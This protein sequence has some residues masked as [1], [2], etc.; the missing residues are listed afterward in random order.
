MEFA[1]SCL[2]QELS[3]WPQQLEAEIFSK[4][5]ATISYQHSH[6]PED[7]NF[8]QHCCE[9][10]KYRMVIS[11]SVPIPPH[12]LLPKGGTGVLISP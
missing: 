12:I 10:P 6:N 2:V 1:S 4:T 8:Y 3:S 11:H 7:L 9:K 5:S